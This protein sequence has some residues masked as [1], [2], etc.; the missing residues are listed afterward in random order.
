[1]KKNVDARIFSL[2][3][4]GNTLQEIA[5]AVRISPAAVRSKLMRS[6]K[7][8]GRVTLRSRFPKDKARVI[9]AMYKKGSSLRDIGDAIGYSYETVRTVLKKNGLLTRR[10]RPRCGIKNC[11]EQPFALGYCKLHWA[12]SRTGRMDERGNLI[13]FQR[14]CKKCGREFFSPP[15]PASAKQCMWCRWR[16]TPEMRKKWAREKQ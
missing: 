14:F 13:P 16:P 4:K 12:R 1:M 10:K 6:G 15:E 9:F 8:P 2:R 3:R 7:F 11:K 5:D